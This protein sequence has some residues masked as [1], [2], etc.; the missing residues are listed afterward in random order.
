M[1]KLTLLRWFGNLA[2]VIGYIIILYNDFTIG[3][4]IKFVG[5]LFLFP[6]FLQLKLWDALILWA[7]FLIIEGTKLKQLY[8]G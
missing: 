5:S 6:S 8:F 7:F 1:N 2:I 3:L 4:T